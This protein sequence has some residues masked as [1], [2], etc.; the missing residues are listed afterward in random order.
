MKW[1]A[2]H[3]PSQ[4]VAAAWRAVARSSS[5]GWLADG[6]TEKRIRPACPLAAALPH[7]GW[8][9]PGRGSQRARS[10]PWLGG[11]PGRGRG[12]GPGGRRDAGRGA[13]RSSAVRGGVAVVT[14]LTCS[15]T[16]LRSWGSMSGRSTPAAWARPTRRSLS[17]AASTA[18]RCSSSVGRKRPAS[19]MVSVWVSASTTSL[20]EADEDRPRVAV[21]ALDVLHGPAGD[22]HVGQEAVA[23][24][25][26]Q[27]VLLAGEAAIQRAH[28]DPARSTTPDTGA[29]G[30]A[31]NTARAAARIASSSRRASARRPASARSGTV[32]TP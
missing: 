22:R 12:R 2:I 4:P 9:R 24:Q 26:A 7:G 13:G 6:H 15:N 18:L 8:R 19:R 31:T 11:R 27:E 30:S 1:S 25:P 21:L 3:T 16:T 17:T 28:V 10:S 23:A 5:Q 29:S 14:W 20:H 32:R